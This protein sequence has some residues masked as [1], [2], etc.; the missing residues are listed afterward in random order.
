MSENIDNDQTQSVVRTFPEIKAVVDGFYDTLP[1]PV[2]GSFA[3]DEKTTEQCEAFKAKI[4]EAQAIMEEIET[5]RLSGDKT[6]T[7]GELGD[8]KK[9]SLQKIAVTFGVKPKQS[10]AAL[11]KEL[12]GKPKSIPVLRTNLWQNE[13]DLG[14][15]TSSLWGR[16]QEARNAYETAS[17]EAYPHPRQTMS[18]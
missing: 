7:A 17:G 13:D 10:V 6:F 9:A 4:D 8:M 14:M 1:G 18:D 12:E 15:K 16:L 2:V 3:R 11:V 5:L